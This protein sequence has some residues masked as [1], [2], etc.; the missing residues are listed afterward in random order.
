MACAAPTLCDARMAAPADS[1]HRGEPSDAWFDYIDRQITPNGTPGIRV[2]RLAIDLGVAAERLGFSP[3]DGIHA[4]NKVIAH[5]KSMHFGVDVVSNAYALPV[6][7]L[8]WPSV[9]VAPA[10]APASTAAATTAAASAIRT[11]LL[12]IPPPPP[13]PPTARRCAG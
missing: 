5:Y 12:Q 8:S 13:P 2:R 9:T 3:S 11:N 10:L 4:L 7:I 6:L 1:R